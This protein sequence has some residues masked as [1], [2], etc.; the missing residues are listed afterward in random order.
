MAELAYD[1]RGSGQPIVLVH[2]LG[3]R[4]RAW[5]PVIERVAAQREVIAVDLSGFGDSPPDASGTE[6][7]IFDHADRLQ[8][9]FEELGIARPHLGGSST[10]GGVVLELGRR[11]AARSVT[12]FS[13]I[14]FWKGPGQAW[15]RWALRAGYEVGQRVPEGMQSL[16]A[17][18]LLMFLYSYGRPFRVPAEELIDAAASGREAAGFLDALTYALA[19]RFGDAGNLRA[20]PL[21]VAWGRRD[22]LLPYWS[23]AR[24]A[25]WALPWA[26]H[27]TLPRCGHIPFYDDP[28]LCA[29]VLLEG[30]S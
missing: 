1:R 9:F 11:G 13:P 21:T 26:R 29:T 16:T 7:T 17:T 3:S 20:I 23:Q 5:S 4:R 6:L 30:S 10:G 25:R 28:Q 12:A 27:V 19:Y 18:R 15:C 2:G 8:R 24:R 22:V 14:G